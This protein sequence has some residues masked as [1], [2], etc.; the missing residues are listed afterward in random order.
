MSAQGGKTKR[1]AACKATFPHSEFHLAKHQKDGRA[2]YCRTCAKEKDNARR[3]VRRAEIDAYKLAR[4]CT[5]CGYNKHPSALQFDHLP[6]TEKLFNI[7]KEGI[8]IKRERLYAEIAKCEVVCANCHVIR[9]VTRY[10]EA[11]NE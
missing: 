6:G 7:G 2:S 10:A 3:A 8:V 4:G 5:D 9:T 11:R 1:C